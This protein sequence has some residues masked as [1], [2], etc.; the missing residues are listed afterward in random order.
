[1]GVGRGVGVEESL[2]VCVSQFGLAVRHWAS[3]QKDL[4]SIPLRLS[5][6]FKGYGLWHLSL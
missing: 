6:L 3:K 1:M 2:T 5:S 4:G